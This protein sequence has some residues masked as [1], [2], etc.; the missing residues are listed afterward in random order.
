LI[1]GRSTAMPRPQ[2]QVCALPL[3]SAALRLMPHCATSQLMKSTGNLL[4]WPSINTQSQDAYLCS[5]QLL[6]C[7]STDLTMPASFWIYCCH[8]EKSPVRLCLYWCNSSTA[9]HWHFCMT[10]PTINDVSLKTKTKITQCLETKSWA[11][12]TSVAVLL[13]TTHDNKKKTKKACS[14]QKMFN[15]KRTYKW[16]LFQNIFW[17]L[18]RILFLFSIITFFVSIACLFNI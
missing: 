6:Y 16:G 7:K 14:I 2:T 9:I 10:N 8:S 15:N 17:W 5:T 11:S 13:L 12:K 18:F 1:E 3:A 4:L